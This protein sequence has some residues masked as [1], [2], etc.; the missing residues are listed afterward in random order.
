MLRVSTNRVSSGVGARFPLCSNAQYTPPLRTKPRH[1]VFRNNKIYHRYDTTVSHSDRS[2]DSSSSSPPACRRER[3]CRNL[4]IT[5]PTQAIWATVP[6]TEFTGHTRQQ[7]P[8]LSGV[9]ELI[10]ALRYLDH[11]VKTDHLSGV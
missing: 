11:P 10:S 1:A 7:G 3:L 5:Y 4:H 6:R 2:S 9:R 8:D